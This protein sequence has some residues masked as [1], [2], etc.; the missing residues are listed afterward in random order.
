MSA[1]TILIAAIALAAVTIALGR[2]RRRK[3]LAIHSPR[4]G[5]LNLKGAAAEGIIASDIEALQPVLGAPSHG[6]A[7]LPFCDVLFVYCDLG[8][9][10]TVAN[11]AGTLRD[12]I[13]KLE[14]PLVVVAS[15]NAGDAYIASTRNRGYGRA[16]LV[17]TLSRQGGAFGPFF[18]QLFAEMKRGISMPVAWARLAPQGAVKGHERLPSTIFACEAGQMIFT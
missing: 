11:F 12:L 18:R 10:G 1:T 9:D 15:E 5:I 2:K 8:A 3:I 7:S 13:R 6:S 16:N 4:F 14:A 17:M